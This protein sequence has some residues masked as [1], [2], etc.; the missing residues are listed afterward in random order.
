VPCAA[1]IRILAILLLVGVLTSTA[2]TPV[3]ALWAKGHT[4]VTRK[5]VDLLQAE[6]AEMYTHFLTFDGRCPE[7][8]ATAFRNDRMPQAALD[9]YYALDAPAKLIQEAP[10]VDD[11]TDLEFVDVEGGIGN[12]GRDD[13][14]KDE[15]VAIDDRPH[16]AE[17]DS[18]LTAFNH[19]IDIRKGPG[20]FDDYDGYSYHRG[21][22]S[23]EQYQDASDAAPGALARLA[24]KLTGYK[25]DHGVNWWFN[26]EYI[27][28][29]GQPWYR[30]CSPSIERYSFPG[31][32]GRY[33][34]V[35]EEAVAR[36]PPANS[37]GGKDKGIPHSVFMPVD[38]LARYWYGRFRDTHDPAVLGPVLHAIQD[39]GVP[40]HAAG[41]L[42]NWHSRY[43]ADLDAGI[44]GW[45]AD[46]G[47]ESEVKALVA[48]WSRGDPSPPTSL[49]PDDWDQTPA[50]NWPVEQLVTWLA[51][52][53]YREY[54]VTYNHFRDGYTL[55]TNSARKLTALATAVSVLVLKK[56]CSPPRV[57]QAP[58][59]IA[60]FPG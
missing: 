50:L 30:A 18:S 60:Q 56:A 37:T 25:V 13:P 55:D 53:S 28:A 38:N 54:A 20:L 40:H 29:P 51:L 57:S 33:A 15:W 4:L 26:D 34:S 43:E 44:P 14:H 23:K 39:A 22:G 36:F 49:S 11:Y 8:P 12:G 35:E 2:A 27:H 48:A 58:H 59:G 3:L 19:F 1:L 9:A 41:T 5:A 45:L 47:F 10:A 46:P 6:S 32:M 16:Y 42:G 24:A 17:D 31:D 7:M 52:N 21:S